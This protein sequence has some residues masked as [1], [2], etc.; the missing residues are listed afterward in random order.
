MS[1]KGPFAVPQGGKS[2]QSQSLAGCFTQLAW[3]MG[4]FAVLV[5]VWVT[6]LRERPWTFTIKDALYWAAVLG[7]IAARQLDVV[8]FKGRTSMGEPATT[9]DVRRYAAGLIASAA[10]L[11][12]LAQTLHV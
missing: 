1:T 6:I 4:G 3:N 10:A 11:W 2:Q 5:S 12:C 9:R 7:M 8:R